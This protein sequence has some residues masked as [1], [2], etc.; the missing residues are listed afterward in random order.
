LPGGLNEFNVLVTNYN[1][2]FYNC[3][4]LTGSGW[5]PTG[6][7]IMG[8]ALGHTV[9]NSADCFK[10]CTSLTGYPNSIP[11]SW[12]GNAPPAP[13]SILPVSGPQAGGTAVT[14]TGTNFVGPAT[15]NIGGMTDFATDVIVVS[16]TS[17]TCKTPV[18]GSAANVNVRVNNADAQSGT[19]SNGYEYT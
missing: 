4:Q 9:S 18:Y 16:L 8:Y 17:I 2:M 3:N 15:V 7:T 1:S 5:G 6:A 11:T 19:L 10:L 14:I 12:G 13:T